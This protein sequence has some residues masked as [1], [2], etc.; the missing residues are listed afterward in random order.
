MSVIVKKQVSE[1][2]LLKSH[3]P[4]WWAN[5]TLSPDGFLDIQS[6]YG[7]YSYAWGAFGDNFKAF[8]IDCDS[9]YIAG[10]IGRNHPDVFNCEKT[11]RAIKDEILRMRRSQDLSKSDARLVWD[12]LERVGIE[13]EDSVYRD[14]P[15]VL[16]HVY[17]NDPSAV[18]W[19]KEQDYSLTAFM[20]RCWPEFIAELK[21]ELISESVPA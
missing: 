6:D 2:Y 8:L 17:Q 21:K 12:E 11:E 7:S 20:E 4:H 14:L 13:W 9:S 15:M 16:E 3:D 10:K 5:I 18:P 19:I 1:R